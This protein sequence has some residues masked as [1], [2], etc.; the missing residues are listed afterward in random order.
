[1]KKIVF[2][3]VCMF[4]MI[5]NHYF[6]AMETN[7]LRKMKLD[8]IVTGFKPSNESLD[9]TTKQDNQNSPVQTITCPECQKLGKHVEISMFELFGHNKFFHGFRYRK[10]IP[11]FCN[12]CQKQT[13]RPDRHQHIK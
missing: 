6:F 13:S 4:T 2:L 1:M 9:T 3:F 7:E 10:T 8:F 11:F 12:V 5:N